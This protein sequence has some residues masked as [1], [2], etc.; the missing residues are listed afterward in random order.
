MITYPLSIEG[1]LT[2]AIEHGQGS[3]L[4]VFIH[5]VGARADRWRANLP[6]LGTPERRCVALDLPG[7]GF[8]A[9]GAG[10]DYSVGGYASFVAAFIRQQSARR[11]YLIGTSLGGHIAA[12]IACRNPQLLSGLM[13]VGATGL[14]PIG[15]EARTNIASRIMD[16]SREG[17]ARKLRHVVADPALV[18]PALIEEE[19][20]V[21]NSPGAT[22]SFA[23]LGRYFVESLDDD[24]IGPALASQSAALPIATLWG[25]VDRSVPLEIGQRA[26][27]LIGEEPLRIIEGAAHAPYFEKAEAFNRIVEAFLSK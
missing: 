5:G 1:T 24:V 2:R 4:V 20:L 12:T 27:E 18:T 3:D 22:E 16:R 8:A 17:I 9:K 19:F 21:N 26:A 7:H 15:L 13:L 25:E 10:F 14:F 6:R 11:T 23:A